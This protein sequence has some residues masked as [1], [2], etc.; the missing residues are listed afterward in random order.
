MEVAASARELKK[1]YSSGATALAG[2]SFEVRPGEIFGLLGPNGAG[3]T[4][5]LRILATLSRATA[6]NAVVCGFDVGSHPKEVRRRIGYLAQTTALDL[7]ATGIE[8][9]QFHGRLMG[10]PAA[11][12]R[13]RARELVELFEL[14]EVAGRQVQTYSGGLKRRLDLA[15]S[16][17]HLPQ[18]LFLDE[19]T[20]GLDPVHRRGLWDQ[21]RDLASRRNVAVLLTTHYMEE[22]DQL[23]RRVAIIDRGCI[24]ATG[25]PA[26]LKSALH[27][28][29][30]TVEL[31]SPANAE[32]TRS[33]LESLDGV[34]RV[35]GDTTGVFAQVPDGS[36]AVP[37]IVEALRIDGIP[38]KRIS[39][40]R[41]TLDEVYLSATGRK[42]EPQLPRATW[43]Q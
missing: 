3:K 33:L 19:P 17:L 40:S 8:N 12:V 24:V 37:S 2:V 31:T 43:A 14:G 32:R 16:L 13:A 7:S 22:A 34:T 27:G 36:F 4:T 26:D 6:G 11:R 30:V 29:I 23:A 21:I 18:V 15:A 5:T 41:P 42:Y 39:I 38:P 25:T 10:L 35:I 28:D 1:T 9:L 20:S